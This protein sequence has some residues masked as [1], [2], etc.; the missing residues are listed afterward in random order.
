MSNL[1]K[2]RVALSI[3]GFRAM[4][5]GDP[6]VG[7]WGLGA[8]GFHRLY[9]HHHVNITTTGSEE[10]GVL[11]IGS[12]PLPVEILPSCQYIYCVM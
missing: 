9:S 8:D 12:R 10:R 3:L 2:G 1:R 11:G 4:R 5:D 6:R 7:V